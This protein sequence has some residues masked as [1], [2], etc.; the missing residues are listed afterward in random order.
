MARQRCAEPLMGGYRRAAAA[1]YEIVLAAHAAAA[2][3]LVD[4][5]FRCLN[6]PVGGQRFVLGA[7]M[8][9]RPLRVVPS[10]VAEK[11]AAGV[12]DQSEQMVDLDL[13]RRGRRRARGLQDDAERRGEYE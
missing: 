4:K 3:G 11:L 10:A 2:G 5:I 1:P 8:G 13:R 12:L 6:L 9:G 7:N